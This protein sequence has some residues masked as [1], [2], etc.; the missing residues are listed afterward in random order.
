MQNQPLVIEGE[1]P[2]QLFMAWFAEAEKTEIN[3][4]NAMSLA[5]VGPGGAPSCRIVLLKDFDERGFCFFTNTLSRKGQQLKA[6][7]VAALCFHWKATRRQVRM[8]G[9]IESVG[10]KEA[11]TY[12][13][14][15]PRGSQIGAWASLQSQRLDR[16]QTLEA[17]VAA[18]EKKYEGMAVPRPPHWSGYRCIPNLIEFWQD[19]PFRLHDRLIFT[20]PDAASQWQQERWFP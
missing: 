1:D 14:S 10:E 7:P 13:A 11:D 3:D 6:Y 12:F 5:T 20:R 15:R 2:F 18:C 4:P 17:R 16:R 8:E 9:K 19:M